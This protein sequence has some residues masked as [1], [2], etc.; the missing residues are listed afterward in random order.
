MPPLNYRRGRQVQDQ[1]S[2][3]EKETT[4]PVEEA[5]RTDETQASRLLPKPS[6]PRTAAH[7]LAAA[8]G[9]GG[10]VGVCRRNRGH[11]RPC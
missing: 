4:T 1:E 2:T 11:R 7:A 10:M 9:W 8:A 5:R 3:L 6:L